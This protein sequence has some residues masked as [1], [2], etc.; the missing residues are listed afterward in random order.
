MNITR[1]MAIV[2]VVA[3]P[4][5]GAGA[6]GLGKIDL[7]HINTDTVIVFDNTDVTPSPY[8]QN[9][10]NSFRDSPAGGQF[11]GAVLVRAPL[12]GQHGA[13]ANSTGRPIG[14]GTKYGDWVSPP[15]EGFVITLAQL[16]G[17]LNR[18]LE[19]VRAAIANGT[20]MPRR[21]VFIADVEIDLGTTQLVIA[22]G[23]TLAGGRGRNGSPG[24]LIKSSSDTRGTSFVILSRDSLGTTRQLAPVRITG[25]R[26]LGPNGREIPPDAWDCSA[27]GRKAISAYEDGNE[28]PAKIVDRVVEI[29]NN[30]FDSWPAMA[31]EIY[32]I[33]GGFVHH[34]YIHHSER[35]PQE[36]LPC[37][38]AFWDWHALEY[39]VNVNNGLVYIEANR[40]EV[41]RHSVASRGSAFTDYVAMYNVLEQEGP[42]HHFDVHGGEDRDDGTHIAGRNIVIAYNTDYGSDEATVNIRGNPVNGAWVIGNQL[43]GS[44]D[45]IKQT[46]VPKSC[47]SVFISTG[48]GGPGGYWTSVCTSFPQG[49]TVQDNIFHYS[50]PVPPSG[51]GGQGPGPG[52]QPG[53]EGNP[54]QQ[55]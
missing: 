22:P 53:S 46:K 16:E 13:A 2:C 12:P 23:L 37:V 32:G 3:L 6:A 20:P 21:T 38:L 45:D 50:D 33:R 14:G 48:P 35:N 44:R 41:N 26:F 5:V 52:W 36:Q 43:R 28:D 24:G 8:V 15:P 10:Q 19:E 47:R 51:P 42:S 49:L 9:A 31:V 7:D 55:K 11:I 17:A 30:E 27:A 29:D 25:L 18:H 4:V 39:G 40:F 54:I 34:N 1:R